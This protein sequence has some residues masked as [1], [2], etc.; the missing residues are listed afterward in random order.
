MRK[1]LDWL[2]IPYYFSSSNKFKV[3]IS[4][5]IGLFVFIFLYVFKPFNLVSLEG[6]L[7]KYT[8]AIGLIAFFGVFFVL[9]IPALIFKNYFNEDN[10]TIGRNLLLIIVGILFN[11]ILIW[12]ITS[13]IKSSEN[14]ENLDLLTF[15][16]YTYLVG[17]IPVVFFIFINEKNVR[18]KREKR[19]QDINKY[20][21][22][23]RELKK[24]ELD[25]KTEIF[26]ENKKESISFNINDLVYITSQGNYASL[27]LKKD[28]EIKEKILRVTLNKVEEKLKVYPNIIRCHKSYIVNSNF[29]IDIEGNARGYLLKSD[30]IPIN[31]PVSRSFSKQSL[32]KLIS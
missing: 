26:S 2:S 6:L 28:E 27:F 21:K 11:G 10:W 1:I 29:V 20:N 32:Q 13:Y 8:S 19:A 18:E 14:F 9:Y 3:K 22:E 17:T 24:K 7:L 4:F 15:L 5:C 25:L 12:Y 30:I 23:K 16:K 31:I